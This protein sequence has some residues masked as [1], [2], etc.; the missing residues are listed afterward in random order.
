V[1]ERLDRREVAPAVVRKRKTSMTTMTT[2]SPGA[3]MR[4]SRRRVTGPFTT[5]THAATRAARPKRATK[6]WS[7]PYAVPAS[8]FRMFTAARP[9][10]TARIPDQPTQTRKFTR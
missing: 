5:T 4:F 6:R 10:I 9:N 7:P 3:A 1:L 2:V 8:S